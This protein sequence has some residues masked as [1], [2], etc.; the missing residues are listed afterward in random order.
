M[1]A[2]DTGGAIKGAQRADIYYGTGSAAGLAA[3]AI[4]DAG[5][6]IMLL[7]IDRAFAML[8]NG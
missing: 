8:P 4:K 5:R 3:G 7:P 6:L 1:V 2:Q